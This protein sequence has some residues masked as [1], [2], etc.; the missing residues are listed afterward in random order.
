MGGRSATRLLLVAGALVLMGLV[1]QAFACTCLPP[2][3]P[4]RELER[5]TAVFAGEVTSVETPSG[6]ITS[7]ADPV[8]ITF[9][10][11]TVWKGPHT[12]TFTITTARSSASCGYAFEMGKEYLVYARGEADDLQVSLCS[13]TKP[14]T[15]ARGDLAELRKGN[16]TSVS[17]MLRAY[18][19]PL[20][21][22]VVIVVAL[23]V[24][25]KLL[26]SR[27]MRL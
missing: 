11:Y 3:S 2:E 6:Q 13:R 17:A 5:S 18:K 19:Y 24:G 8:A 27:W 12:N 4:E 23:G 25:I 1:Q 21:A 10:V 15:R 22:A 9:E 7:S 14:L 16:Q 26:V 20:I